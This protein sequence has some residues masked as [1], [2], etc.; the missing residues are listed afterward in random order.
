MVGKE[1]ASTVIV[2]GIVNV[3]RWSS[4]RFLCSSY[5]SWYSASKLGSLAGR[6]EWKD[7]LLSLVPR[8]SEAICY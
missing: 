2:L 8:L 3:Q 7:M 4:K 1:E 6:G 5:N